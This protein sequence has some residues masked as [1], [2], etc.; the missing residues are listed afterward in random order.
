MGPDEVPAGEDTLLPAVHSPTVCCLAVSTFSPN[1]QMI[2]K[3]MKALEPVGKRI[4]RKKKIREGNREG[5]YQNALYIHYLDK[6][7]F[8]KISVINIYSIK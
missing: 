8:L 7:M 3:N 1:L 6:E 5:Y 4:S 2:K